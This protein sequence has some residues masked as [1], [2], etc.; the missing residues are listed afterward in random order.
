[1]TKSHSLNQRLISYLV[2]L[3]LLLGA[4]IVLT[5]LAWMISTSLKEESQVFLYPPQL[6][7]NPVVWRNYIDALT[8][9]PFSVYF[10]NSIIVS[11]LAIVGAVLSSSLVAY[12]FARLR[13]R[14]RDWVFLL[15]LATMM[16]P[17]QVTI[18]PQF[19]I[20]RKLGWLNT[21]L[22]LFV[23]YWGA[24]A[25]FVFLLRQFFTTIPREL[26]DAALIDGCSLLGIFWR[27]S[28]PLSKPAL[29]AVAIFAFQWSW[30]DFF[31][32]LV[33]I[34][35]RENWTVAL[36]LAAYRNTFGTTWN[37]LMAA[38]VATILP[39]VLVFF[40]A[41]RYFIQGVVFTGLKG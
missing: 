30:N 37:L 33:Y 40:F 18:I 31:H 39:L 17:G 6:F 5:P 35:S 8:V 20:F 36:G 26:D 15:V 28:L 25:F 4:L 38:S 21:L 10:K 22:P 32:A 2:Y 12:S 41:Q 14:G 27:I 9:L 1:M 16:L 3:L 24:G 34:N 23:P 11:S 19:L 13:W 29:A 7:P